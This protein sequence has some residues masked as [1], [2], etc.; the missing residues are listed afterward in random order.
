MDKK[1][2][3]AHIRVLLAF[4]GILENYNFVVTSK[5]FIM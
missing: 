3:K 2:Q 1:T 5:E 4:G